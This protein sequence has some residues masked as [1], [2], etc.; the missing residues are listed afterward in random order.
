MQQRWQS[1]RQ[2]RV[3]LRLLVEGSQRPLAVEECRQRA[4]RDLLLVELEAAEQPGPALQPA[5][6]EQLELGLLYRQLREREG[7]GLG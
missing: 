1:L 2:L 6:R 3:P 5:G 7:L 4:K